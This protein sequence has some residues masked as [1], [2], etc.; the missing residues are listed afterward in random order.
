MVE[1]HGTY[2]DYEWVIIFE[3][4]GHRCG[5]VG[6]PEEH[7]FYEKSEEELP[8]ISCHGGISITSHG[9]AGFSSDDWLIGFD[10]AHYPLDAIDL[11]SISRYF[12]DKALDDIKCSPSMFEYRTKGHAWTADEVE[13]ECKSIINQI[14][15]YMENRPQVDPKILNE[16]NK[17]YDDFMNG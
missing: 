9:N 8:N 5:Y 15:K 1:R 6:I 3:Q 17:I 16:I 13:E 12:G 10:C 14:I 2:R 7:P 4:D 11:T